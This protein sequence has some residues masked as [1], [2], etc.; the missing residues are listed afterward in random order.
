MKE[1]MNIGLVGY[2]KMGQALEALIK[3]SSIG[4]I[5]WIVDPKQAKAH[6]PQL[7]QAPLNEID[8]CFEFTCP[9]SASANLSHL[10]ENGIPTISGTTGCN[11]SKESLHQKALDQEIGLVIASNFSI[12]MNLFYLLTE[13]A[14][15]L[16]ASFK[17]YDVSG[18]E[19]HHR[20]KL[21]S[22]SGTAKTLCEK[23]IRHS[24][25]KKKA[26]FDRL[27]QPQDDILHFSSLRCGHLVGQ[28]HIYFD[29][30]DDTITLSHH[31]KERSSFAKGAILAAQC[32]SNKKGLFSME[33]IL[34]ILMDRSINNENMERNLHSTR[35]SL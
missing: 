14:S 25:I 1:F 29:S 28:H 15:Q 27:E 19:G 18:F 5:Q 20:E 30:L 3:T 9:Q 13:Q 11:L 31:A 24:F 4:N 6:Y 26:H 21:D 10:V 35:H 8:I 12:G 32:I 7:S 33:D 34:L 17:E 2:G 22:P 23:I 16:F